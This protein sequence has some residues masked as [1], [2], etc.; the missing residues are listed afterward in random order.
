MNAEDAARGFKWFKEHETHVSKM[1]MG[2]D[3]IP[4]IEPSGSDAANPALWKDIHW[5]WFFTQ[6]FDND[7]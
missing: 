2:K 4:E 1:L 3:S 5:A 6:R 7:S